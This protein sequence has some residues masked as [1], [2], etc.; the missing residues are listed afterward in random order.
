MADLK[1]LEAEWPAISQR[2]DEALALAP[3]ERDTW[4]NALIETDSIKQKLRQLLTDAASIETGDFLGTLPKL[5]LGADEADKQS[6]AHAAAIGAVIG[7]YRLI[8]ELGAGGM[9]AVWLA[10]RIDGTLKREVALKLPRL[11]W[12][13]G[14]AERMSRERDILA[15]LNHPHIARIY[16]A[17]LDE[18]GRPYLALEYVE[19]E[20]IDIYCKQHALPIRERLK[21]MLQVSAA[22][23]H[24]HA[25]L[26]LHRDLKPANILVTHEGQVRLLDFGIAK[27]MEGELT[28]ETKLT[29]QSGRALTL[30]YA[31]P[32]QIRGEA[33]GTAS[34]VYSLGV[35]AYELLTEAKPYKLKRESAAALEEAI[36]TVDV[37]LASH[38]ATDKHSKQQLKG[39]ID[40][41]LNKA[42]KKDVTARYPTVDALAQ[43]I[44]RHLNNLPVQ[45]RPDAWGYRVQKFLGRNKLPVAAA[46]AVSITLIAGVAGVLWQARVA[47]AQTTRAERVKDFVLSIFNDANSDSEAGTSRSAADLLKLARQRVN[48]ETGGN[49]EL[50]VELM[51]AIGKSMVGQGLSADAATLMR[52]AVETSQ[53]KL[54][55]Q[56]RLTRAAQ[57]VYGMTLLVLGRNKDVI[58][59][60]TPSIESARLAGDTRTLVRGLGTLSNAYLSDGQLEAGIE[61]A[62]QAVASLSRG[63]SLGDAQTLADARDAYW[64][65]AYALHLAVRPGAVDAAQRSL[66]FAREIAGQ[67]MTSGI[68]KTKVLLA[69]ALASEGQLKEALSELDT[70]IPAAVELFGP[71]HKTVADTARQVGSAKQDAGD[72][73]GAIV[74]MRRA[75]DVYDMQ[76]G[77]VATPEAIAPHLN[78][79]MYRFHLAR[80][81][82]AARQPNNALPLLKEAV[83]LLMASAGPTNSVTI[84]AMSM[85]AWQ[86]AEAGRIAEAEEEFNVLPP[87]TQGGPD[88]A[89]AQ[90]HLS[91]LRSLQ[92]RHEEALAL[93]EL[94]TATMRNIPRKGVQARFLTLL[95]TAQV[96]AGYAQKALEPL[97]EAQALFAKAELG[98]SP[99]HAEALV[100]LGR[101][102]MQLGDVAAAVPFLSSADQAWQAFDAKNRRAGLAKLYLAQALWAQGE[103][104]TATEEL[105][106]ADSILANSVFPADHALL[107]S[108]RQRFGV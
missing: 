105:R 84:R 83:S 96:D 36:A 65:Y 28:Q 18:Q 79:G 93:A 26:V 40:A 61:S 62:R 82:V 67:K 17:G 46:A 106:Q 47:Q 97:T 42:L 12:S 1:H 44:E 99:D 102:R 94:S 43:D 27:L 6:G 77:G 64:H 10:E 70:L 37:R 73:A 86:L 80:A 107:K 24:A 8:R 13:S 69:Q 103:R 104:R 4:L 78:R 7:P 101:A 39:D 57:Q 74:A 108:S 45:A 35:V 55:E 92:G 48:N 41:I 49:P 100:A 91:A 81:Y 34:D 85:H 71:R 98:I 15:S 56:H 59:A 75:V 16:D 89:G 58:A 50:A 54:G 68:L 31:S 2:L 32:E 22:V 20:P 63:S 88:L 52:E 11:S 66:S 53:H 23:A 9:G 30:D 19:G 21:L 25:R 60:V 51:T 3:K 29:Q 14:L 90:G 33:I 95:G 87:I 76:E 5:T 38:A 72:V